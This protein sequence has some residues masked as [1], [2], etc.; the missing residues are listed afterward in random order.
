MVA[1]PIY[2]P[3]SFRILKKGEKGEGELRTFDYEGKG[4]HFEADEVARC[5]RD[6]KLES[7]LWSNDKA[8]LAMDIFD[9]VRK[10]GGYVFPAGLE[11]VTA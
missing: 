9:E 11:K 10:Q 7:D 5:V 3:R 8:I 6:G 2:C 1:P 4:W